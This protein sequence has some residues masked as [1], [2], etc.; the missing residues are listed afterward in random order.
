MTVEYLDLA[1]YLAIAAEVTALDAD[2]LMRVTNLPLADSA[3]H[4]PA[5]GFG[6]TEFYP[7]F[8]E[9]AAVLA[10]RLAKNHPLPDGNK[11]A[12]WVALRVFIEIN[13]WRWES[14]V[15]DRNDDLGAARARE[16]DVVL[17][18]TVH[19]TRRDGQGAGLSGDR[20]GG[21]PG[22]DAVDIGEHGGP[23][24]ARVDDVSPPGA[25]AA[26]RH[27]GRRRSQGV[28]D[29]RL[30]A[31]VPAASTVLIVGPLPMVTTSGQ[32]SPSKSATSRRPGLGPVGIS[33]RGVLNEPSPLPW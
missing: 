23:A 5:A 27:V 3:L 25:E 30:E 24:G 2:T 21:R 12:A 15:L 16:Q 6:E 28:R 32:P 19:V 33:E 18:V 13:G 1:D 8:V 22:D 29:G 9:K 10:V 11:R 14:A 4:A 17:A 7:D 26:E 31:A 20:G